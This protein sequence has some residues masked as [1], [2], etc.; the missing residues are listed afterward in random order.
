MFFFQVLSP[1]IRKG[2][3]DAEEDDRLRK[4]V[5]AYPCARNWGEVSKKMSEGLS[6]QKSSERWFSSSV[7]FAIVFSG[8]S[9]AV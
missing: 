3:W 9:S 4:V 7:H 6:G 8:S 1:L 5:E 2:Q